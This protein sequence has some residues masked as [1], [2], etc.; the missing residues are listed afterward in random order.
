M[1]KF[2]SLLLVAL[3]AFGL[4]GCVE[5]DDDWDDDDR[6]EERDDDDRYE[7]DDDEGYDD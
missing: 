7:D 1:K 2:L 6:Y 5:Q 3:L 4:V